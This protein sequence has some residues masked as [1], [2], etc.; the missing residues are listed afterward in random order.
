MSGPPLLRAQLLS[1]TRRQRLPHRGGRRCVFPLR[2]LQ[3]PPHR[4]RCRSAPPPK[5]AIDPAQFL[6]VTQFSAVQSMVKGPVSGFAFRSDAWN[7]GYRRPGT[8]VLGAFSRSHFLLRFSDSVGGSVLSLGPGGVGNWLSKHEL[9]ARE[10]PAPPLAQRRYS[11]ARLARP[12]SLAPPCVM[13]R[14][15]SAPQSPPP[16]TPSQP[17]RS[18]PW[19]ALPAAW[20]S[21]LQP[22]RATLPSLLATL[23]GPL[24]IRCAPPTPP[25]WHR[26]HMLPSCFHPA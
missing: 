22:T 26:F 24:G 6:R 8:Q 10:A 9:A 7:G 11:C 23:Q 16:Q 14:P 5:Q 21:L 3:Q 18:G 13:F 15:C 4:L 1:P 20:P 12:A 17:P 25:I 2:W 19:C